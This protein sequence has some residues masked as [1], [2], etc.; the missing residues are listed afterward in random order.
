MD[1][2]SFALGMKVGAGKGAGGGTSSDER[3]KY[4]TFMYGDTELLKYPV[5]SGDTCRDPVAKGYINTPTKE[6]TVSIVYTHSG[7][8][9]TDGGAASSS[10]LANV[11]EDRTVYVSFK[12]D[13][14]M[15]T[16]NFYDGDELLKSEQVAYGTV[17]SYTP[18]KD[19]YSFVEWQPAIAEVTGDADYY[20]QWE[21]KTTF[22][23]SSWADIAAI[24][25]SGQAEEYFKVGDTRV[26]SIYVVLEGTFNF[27]FTVVGF[28]HDDLSD[29]GGKAGMSI[30][31]TTV[32]PWTCEW[33]TG[34]TTS[35][36]PN[37]LI[38]TRLESTVFNAL[39]EGLREAIKT[40]DKEYDTTI[41]AGAITK[42]VTPCTLWLPS[43][44]EIGYNYIVHNLQSSVYN[45]RMGALGTRYEYF[46][47]G[48]KTSRLHIKTGKNTSYVTRQ[49]YRNG[50]GAAI[51]G[52]D[53]SQASDYNIMPLAFKG[54]YY[55]KY[56]FLFGFCI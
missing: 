5:L 3:V 7:W 15:Y 1:I 52:Y 37:S 6:P 22:A 8:S 56:A 30:M 2:L 54:D 25:E 21:E 27:T 16:I 32:G 26:E 49:L 10:A 45:D 50:T 12:A 18:T 36:Y 9:L 13:P 31:V 51:C 11:T 53:A 40:V 14:R 39:P 17:P 28:N 24:S 42:D 29:G 35:F 41:Y 55:N 46:A 47:D 4:V 43:P 38:K 23:G 19:G 34:A 33:S 48:S 44:A 20:A